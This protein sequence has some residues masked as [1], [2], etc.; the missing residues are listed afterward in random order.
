MK[1][2]RTIR[3]IL[4]ALMVLGAF[5]NF[6]QNDYGIQLL[7]NCHF[8]I[9]LTF[10]FEAATAIRKEFHDNKLIA[11]TRFFE[12]LF[13]GFV[14]LGFYL[15]LRHMAGGSQLAVLAFFFLTLQ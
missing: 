11:L 8:W 6:A 2:V 3:Y 12:H 10:F 13:I 14:F 4:F 5:A 1:A 15:R 7:Y 9:A